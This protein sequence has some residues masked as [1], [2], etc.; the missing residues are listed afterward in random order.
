MIENNLSSGIKLYSK[1]RY[2]AALLPNFFPWG[3]TPSENPELAY[4]LGLC[5]TKLEKYDEALLY[6]EQVVTNHTNLILIYQ[7]RMILG[8]IY[9]VTERF[10]LAEFEMKQLVDGGYESPQVYSTMGYINYMLNRTD[11]SLEALQKALKLD[12]D[13]RQCP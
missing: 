8:Y 5:Y 6:L 3:K 10:R 1:K 9:C 11:A 4:Y 12:P 2:E 13:K 7:S